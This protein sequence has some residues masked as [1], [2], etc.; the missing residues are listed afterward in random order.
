MC[1]NP[2]VPGRRSGEGKRQ[3]CFLQ[4]DGAT[5]VS[6]E[7]TTSSDTTNREIRAIDTQ[8]ANTIMHIGF[9]LITDGEP[10]DTVPRPKV[11]RIPAGCPEQV[12]F[13]ASLSVVC[14]CGARTGQP[15]P[16]GRAAEQT[17]SGALT[18]HAQPPCGVAVLCG[19]A[20]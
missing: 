7:T 16:C 9:L 20:A 8:A 19:M 5:F 13:S 4:I 15:W 3:R 12:V 18:T 10:R 17:R 2:N 6:D 11:V 1:R 14:N